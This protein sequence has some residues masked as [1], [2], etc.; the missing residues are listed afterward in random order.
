MWRRF[1]TKPDELD[2]SKWFSEPLSP[3]FAEFL[4]RKN[5]ETVALQQQVTVPVT[6]EA[7]K[8]P[9]TGILSSAKPPTPLASREKWTAA[10]K[11]QDEA[12]F[13][14][15]ARQRQENDAKG[16]KFQPQIHDTFVK[17]N[18]DG[19]KVGEP[20]VM[21]YQARVD[22]P[23][24]ETKAQPAPKPTRQPEYE[25]RSQPE[26][27]P[28]A[29]ATLP[30][31][32]QPAPKPA[33]Q[34]RP[35][36]HSLVLSSKNTPHIPPQS[37]APQCSIKKEDCDEGAC[38]WIWQEYLQSWAAKSA[39]A[40]NAWEVSIPRSKDCYFF[41]ESGNRIFQVLAMCPRG[42][43]LYT[44]YRGNDADNQRLVI[45]VYVKFSKHAQKAKAKQAKFRI[46]SGHDTNM[47]SLFRLLFEWSTMIN[48]GHDI[49]F[50]LHLQSHN[51]RTSR[52]LA[53]SFDTLRAEVSARVDSAKE[54][55]ARAEEAERSRQELVNKAK[56]EHEAKM[57]AER[58]NLEK[59][60][61]E[62]VR[63]FSADRIKIR[64][65]LKVLVAETDEYCQNDGQRW[66]IIVRYI[67]TIEPDKAA[68]ASQLMWDQGYGK[69]RRH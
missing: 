27:K 60:T 58:V 51:N 64:Q 3:E 26:P 22:S 2:E 40:E 14:S 69:A 57:E 65:Q 61:G 63:K 47:I 4:N 45:G 17:T 49:L 30:A 9:P 50:S 43:H 12:Y 23:K 35:Q 41:G 10:A 28:E 37:E 15:C 48:L 29:K 34:R 67:S 13:A 31:R 1:P 21:E 11:G 53:N 55:H 59:S 32:P 19:V 36:E 20:E 7:S 46:T 38:Q 56:A 54:S 66:Q 52:M 6:K 44:E 25:A 8:P 5:A 24:P 42:A 16:I 33:S 68:W 18:E 39:Y 62:I